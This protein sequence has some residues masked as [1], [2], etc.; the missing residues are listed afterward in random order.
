MIKLNKQEVAYI[1]FPN[2]EVGIPIINL[3]IKHFNIIEWVYQDDG[4]IVKLAQHRRI[5]LI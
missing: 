2:G 5:T 4:E 1:H 3:D